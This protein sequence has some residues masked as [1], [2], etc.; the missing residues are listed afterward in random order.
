MPPQQS[1]QPSASS[2]VR[3]TPVDM[4]TEVTQGGMRR[5][6]SDWAIA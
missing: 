6:G 2:A 4:D 1:T 3:R 5:E